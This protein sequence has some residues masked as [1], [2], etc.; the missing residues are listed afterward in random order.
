MLM[1]FPWHVYCSKILLYGGPDCSLAVVLRFRL[2][3]H[4]FPDVVI[5]FRLREEGAQNQA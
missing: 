2:V 5:V 4:N 1:L 3:Y